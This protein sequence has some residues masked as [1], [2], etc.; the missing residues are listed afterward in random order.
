MEQHPNTFFVW[1]N[2]PPQVEG[3]TTPAYAANEYSFNRW[4][5]DSLATGLDSY[6]DFPENVY[7][8]DY[9]DVVES[10]NFLPLSLADGPHDSHPNAACSELVAPLFVQ[11]TFNAAIAYEESLLP[12]ELSS[13]S[14]SI[15]GSIVKLNWKTE[16]EVS[17]Y[18]FDIE[19]KAGSRL[20]EVGNFEKI[21]FVEGHG[22]SNSPKYYSFEDINLTTGKYSYRL[23]QIDTDGQFEY[24]K[25]IEV[26]LDAPMKYELSQNYPN[27]FNPITTIQFSIPQ[28][29]EVKLMIYNIL[30]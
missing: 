19:R 16:T 15:I 9:F 28:A 18:G 20:S 24:S 10:T 22:N 7:I 8:F 23:K 1:W 29:V 12:V 26:D 25:V 21:G 27:P 6:G 5:K 13:F 4:M 2:I 11:E 14:A 17:N 3:E 30:R